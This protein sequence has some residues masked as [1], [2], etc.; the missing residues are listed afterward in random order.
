M[1]NWELGIAVSSAAV[2]FDRRKNSRPLSSPSS[3]TFRTLLLPTSSAAVTRLCGEIVVALFSSP[4]CPLLHR[5]RSPPP[6]PSHFLFPTPERRSTFLRG[7]WSIWA[8]IVWRIPGGT[9]WWWNRETEKQRERERTVRRNIKR[10]TLHMPGKRNGT[11]FAKWCHS[12]NFLE[13]PSGTFSGRNINNVPRPR[14][15]ILWLVAS[16]ELCHASAWFRL[17]IFS[18]RVKFNLPIFDRSCHHHRVNWNGIFI[19]H[20]HARW[21]RFE[22]LTWK[23]KIYPDRW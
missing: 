9:S 7:C 23:L 3:S 15:K 18:P 10:T 14:A 20:T 11:T 17:G 2:S 8:N 13:R 16:A 19:F 4:P 1:P 22:L 6:A 12:F 5:L 21:L